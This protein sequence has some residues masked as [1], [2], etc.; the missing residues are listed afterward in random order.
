LQNFWQV[1]GIATN[2]CKEIVRYDGETVTYWY[3]DHET[4]ARK[5][6]S[7]DVL[8]FY[9][10]KVQ[11]ILPKGFQRI[12]YYGLQA[13]KTYEKWSEVIKKKVLMNFCKQYRSL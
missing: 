10:R 3:N 6:E 11:H 1:H 2:Q 9:G 13:T 12:R 4:K 7:L 5:E 8:T